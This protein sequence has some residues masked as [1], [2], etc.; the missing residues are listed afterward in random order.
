MDNSNFRKRMLFSLVAISGRDA[1]SFSIE[2]REDQVQVFGPKAQAVYPSGHWISQFS[3]HLYSGFF[4]GLSPRC[5][6]HEEAERAN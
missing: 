1:G 2:E 6:G 3:R 5:R 4:E